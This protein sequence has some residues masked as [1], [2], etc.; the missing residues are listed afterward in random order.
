M[1]AKTLMV[2]QTISPRVITPL[3]HSLAFVPV[4]TLQ[5]MKAGVTVTLARFCV[6]SPAGSHINIFFLTYLNLTVA[7][8]K[9]SV[10]LD[11]LDL[12]IF[13][14]KQVMD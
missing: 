14:A 1:N 3:V 9:R 13:L 2:A 11:E 6:I 12:Y 8:L 7:L 10:E 4:V 5:T